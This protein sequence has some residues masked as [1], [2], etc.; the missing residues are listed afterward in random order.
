MKHS[1]ARSRGFTLIELMI[2]VSII[3]ILATIALPM[4]IKYTYR[5][6]SVEA[7]ANL[8][9]IRTSMVGFK[10]NEDTYLDIQIEPAQPVTGLK[11]AWPQLPPL[12]S[13]ATTQ[14]GR[15]SNIGFQPAGTVY[16]H[17]GCQHVREA[18]RCEASSDIDLTPPQ[19]VWMLA[20]REET[21]EAVPGPFAGVTPIREWGAPV[22]LT[23]GT[24]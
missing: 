24:Y 13:P 14:V 7:T 11:K 1:R 4:Y 21:E 2:T 15:F 12:P 16:Y 22:N 20:W 18:V 10:A 19:Q 9:A 5:A 23:F 8:G 17:Y 3:G 6:K